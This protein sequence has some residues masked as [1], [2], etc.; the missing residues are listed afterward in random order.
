MGAVWAGRNGQAKTLASDASVASV[1]NDLRGMLWVV[2][3]GVE[4]G[5]AE[6]EGIEF[7]MERNACSGQWRSFHIE[8]HAPD[9]IKCKAC[10]GSIAS[11]LIVPALMQG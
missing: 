1:L 10:N 6:V 11:M 4:A 5:P 3:T 9:R 2:E 7:K 8:R